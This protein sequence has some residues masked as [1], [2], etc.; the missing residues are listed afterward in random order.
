MRFISHWRFSLGTQLGV[1]CRYH[2]P[3]LGWMAVDMEG[4]VVWSERTP[5][6]V[7]VLPTYETTLLFLDLPDDLRQG[8]REF[9][10]HLAV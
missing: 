3:R 6:V 2:H 9:S 8:V 10:H 5:E 4:I 1:R 7:G